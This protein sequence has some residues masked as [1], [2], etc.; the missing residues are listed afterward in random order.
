MKAADKPAH[1]G[2]VMRTMLAGEGL[3]IST[4]A[5]RLGVSRPNLH[6]VLAGRTALSPLMAVKFARLTGVDAALLLDMQVRLELWRVEQCYPR[7]KDDF[8]AR[9]S[10]PIDADG[11]RSAGVGKT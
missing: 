1:P 4:A 7:R 8:L 10:A 9:G 5:R 6:S 2:T 3:T 11:R